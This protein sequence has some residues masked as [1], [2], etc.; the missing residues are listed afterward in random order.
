MKQG[1]I[2]FNGYSSIDDMHMYMTEYPSLQLDSEEYDEIDIEGRNGTLI[3]NKGTFKN[4]ILEFKFTNQ[5]DCELLFDLDLIQL[6]LTNYKDNKLFYGR[7]DKC[8]LVK[9]VILGSFQQEMANRGD[10]S[11]IFICE[12]FI[13]E[14]NATNYTVLSNNYKFNYIGSAPSFPLIRVF[15]SGNIQLTVNE[16]TILLNDVDG[17]TTIDNRLRQFRD[18]NEQSKDLQCNG[19]FVCLDK[20]EYNISYSGNVT[21]IELNFTTAYKQ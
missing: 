8:Y 20:G 18:K 14:P 12:P 19:N 3:K 10:I 21:R 1:E 6:W 4:K 15:G 11:V 7:D 2:R 16:Q 5:S 17:Y 13:Y 9:K